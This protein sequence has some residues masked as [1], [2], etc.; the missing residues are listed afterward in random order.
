MISI[1]P[2]TQ[3]DLL[4]LA[5]LHL[6]KSDQ[7]EIKAALGKTPNIALVDSAC[8]ADE[9]HL[10]LEDNE[11]IGVF[12]VAVSPSRAY[13]SPWFVCSD[14]AY[15]HKLKLLRFSKAQVADW[16]NEYGVLLNYVDSRHL[17]SIEWLEWLG[18]TIEYN[19]KV[20]LHDPEV[21]F[22]PF[23]MEKKE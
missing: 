2:F 21:L 18:F 14:R 17:A 13:A 5:T 9:V 19:T 10:I 8:K 7:E 11:V 16:I 12:G 3:L 15:Q 1:R 23:Y 20:K 6:R 4:A 22:H